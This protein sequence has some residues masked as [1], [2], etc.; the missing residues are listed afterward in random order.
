MKKSLFFAAAAV[1]MLTGCSQNDDLTAPTVAQNAQQQTAIEFGTY[2]GKTAQT[3]SAYEKGPID[4]SNTD[5]GLKNAQFGVFSYLTSADYDRVTPTAQRPDFMYNQQIEW[6]T[7]KWVYQPVKYW[8]NGNDAA[9]GADNPSNTAIQDGT[10]AKKLSFFAYAPYKAFSTFNTDGAGSAG[11][12]FPSALSATTAFKTVATPT[13]ANGIVGM[14]TNA[15]TGNVWVQYGLPKAQTDEAVDLLWGLRG[16][17]TYTETDGGNNTGTVSTDY[18]V[19]LTKQ[20]TAEKVSFLFKHALSK[21]DGSTFTTA[22]NLDEAS[23]NCG[24]KIKLDVDGNNGDN[25]QEYFGSGNGFDNAKTLVTVKKVTIQDGATAYSDSWTNLTAST[26]SDILKW[27]WFNIE[28]GS[29]DANARGTGG[30]INITVQND[31]SADAANTNTYTLNPAIRE[32]TENPAVKNATGVNWNSSANSSTDGYTGGASGVTAT[33]VPLYANEDAAGLIFIPG[34]DQT[35]Y[36]TIEYVVRTA[37]ANLSTGFTEVT[38]KI[39]NKVTL[40][41]ATLGANKKF[42]LIMHLGLTSVKFEAIVS[43]WQTKSGSTIGE[44]GH[45]TGGSTNNEQKVW[46]PSNVVVTP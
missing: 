5:Q 6:S 40:P 19:N 14:T 25:Q 1:A 23:S 32:N 41:G 45:E 20:T 31:K 4:N 15:F 17:A 2:L 36:V 39:T 37:D 43:D 22:K 3:R 33:A 13:T 29:W 38:Q 28:T 42:D 7:D 27:G 46:L 44:D 26:T 8:P 24:I 30:T 10:Y 21:I 34:A 9:N 18:N 16:S 35:I 12:D 11:T